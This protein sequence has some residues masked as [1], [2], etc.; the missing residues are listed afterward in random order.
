MREREG[1][2]SEEDHLINERVYLTK[3]Q[4]DFYY[5]IYES[6]VRFHSS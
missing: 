2:K 6:E 1:E 5:L 3:P 4:R